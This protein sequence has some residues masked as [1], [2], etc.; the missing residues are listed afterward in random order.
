MLQGS[1]SEGREESGYLFGITLLFQ[2]LTLFI[3]LTIHAYL[4]VYG[5]SL[6]A[7][8]FSTAVEKIGA[9]EDEDMVKLYY[10]L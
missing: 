3:V 9:L 1:T 2:T 8:I 10:D 6:S 5:L 7:L 4:R